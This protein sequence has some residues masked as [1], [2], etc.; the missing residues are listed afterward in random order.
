M[1]LLTEYENIN[2][3]VVFGNAVLAAFISGRKCDVI[4][5]NGDCSRE[6]Y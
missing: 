5:Q 2:Q 3:T 4:L 1:K 6:S